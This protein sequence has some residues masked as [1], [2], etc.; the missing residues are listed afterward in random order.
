MATL[1]TSVLSLLSSVPD[2]RDISAGVVTAVRT[3][4]LWNRGS[5]PA[6]VKIFSF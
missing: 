1:V 4:E 2:G 6:R 5:I 3:E